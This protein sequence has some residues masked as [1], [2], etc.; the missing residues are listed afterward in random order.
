MNRQIN[1]NL[2]YDLF[3]LKELNEQVLKELEDLRLLLN[4]GDGLGSEKC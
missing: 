4:N 1:L 2:L 3:K